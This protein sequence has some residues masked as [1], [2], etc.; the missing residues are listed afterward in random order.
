M[1]AARLMDDNSELGAVTADLTIN[2]SS[3][4]HRSTATIMT[5]KSAIVHPFLPVSSNGRIASTH[6]T[7]DS[8][9]CPTCLFQSNDTTSQTLTVARNEL[10]SSGEAFCQLLKGILNHNA[11]KTLTIRLRITSYRPQLSA[12]FR[13]AAATAIHSS[14]TKF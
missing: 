4:G 6:M 10:E 2:V 13:C 11:T 3:C 8:P 9:I 5:L 12:Q 1:R 14:D 7:S